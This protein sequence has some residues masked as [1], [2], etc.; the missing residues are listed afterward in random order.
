M[1]ATADM[2]ADPLQ[3]GDPR[4]LGPYEL[5]GRLGAGGQGAVFLGRGS[6]QDLVA[7]KLLRADLA[8]DTDARGRFVREAMAARQVARF[9]A[10]QV[11]D[12][13]VAG[14]RPYIVS[15]YVQ[16]PSL[17]RLVRERG[18]ISGAAL[19]R[20]AIG[21]A[22]ALVAIHQAG[23]VHRD[24]KPANVLV[25]S[26]GPR[27]IDFGIA[28]ALSGTSTVSS[29]IIGTPAYMAPEQLRGDSLTPAV[30]VFAWA[31]TMVF[32]GTGRPP[33]GA[34]AIPHVVNRIMSADPDLGDMSGPVRALVTDC[35]AKDPERRPSARHILLRLL[36]EEEVVPSAT[37]EASG[38]VDSDVLAQ[39]ATLAAG[40]GAMAGHG[41]AAGQESPAEHWAQA[42]PEQPPQDQTV[43]AGMSHTHGGG[44]PHGGGQGH[45]GGRGQGGPRRRAVV[46]CAGGL[47]AAA[48]AVSL[49][50]AANADLWKRQGTGTTSTT[51]SPGSQAEIPSLNQNGV[52]TDVDAGLPRPTSTGTR[53]PARA[54]TDSRPTGRPTYT[55]RPTH[56]PTWTP[57]A[58]PS[59][60]PTPSP[61]TPTE[62]SGGSGG[63]HGSGDSCEPG[64]CGAA[65]DTHDG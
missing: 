55:N 57:P 30:D 37:P 48:A 38:D 61:G 35:L 22:T 64:G 4:T 41:P 19:E 12:A 36:A 25:A 56:S 49:V 7:I 20:L 58:T 5:I 45:S 21:T 32:V 1:A 15:E 52:P 17:L 31:A 44:H 62:M 3:P 53:T 11:L 9:C 51:S 10:A 59:W 18:P 26:D 23:I 46:A 42:F 13:D 50:M 60:T 43:Q 39:A 40:H 65:P 14:D 54:T 34:D 24:L 27:V 6:S 33:F 29:Q 8:E 2:S 47:V 28:K 16:G 63:G